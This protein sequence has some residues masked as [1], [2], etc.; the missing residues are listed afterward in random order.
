MCRKAD[1][2]KRQDRYTCFTYVAYYTLMV[3]VIATVGRKV[4]CNR[5]TFLT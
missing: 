1:V 5:Q 3:G 4:E 2:Y